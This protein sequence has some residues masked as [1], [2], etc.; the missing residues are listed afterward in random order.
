[1]LKGVP[2]I[3]SP[4]LM[5]VLMDMGHGD[6]LVLADGNFPAAAMARRLVRAD[7]LAVPPLLE[8]IL[9]FFPLDQYVERPAILMQVVPGD[10]TKPTIWEEYRKILKADKKFTEFEQIERHAFYQRARDAFAVV[11]TSEAALYANIILKKGVVTL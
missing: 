2:A 3:L 11:A 8:A 4:D 5:K 6:E 9:K 1:M 10:P 7:G